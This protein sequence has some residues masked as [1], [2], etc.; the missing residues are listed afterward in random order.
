MDT[1][2]DYGSWRA[3]PWRTNSSI[4]WTLLWFCSPVAPFHK[5]LALLC[6]T[7][8]GCML[9][10]MTLSSAV[11]I[12]QEA[13]SLSACKP[14]NYRNRSPVSH[15]V[16]NYACQWFWFDSADIRAALSSR[17]PF[18]WPWVCASSDYGHCRRAVFKACDFR[19]LCFRPV[20]LKNSL[21]WFH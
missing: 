2:K 12:Q 4:N 17:A 5:L 10:L 3:L 15:Y 18:Q 16:D 8:A 19:W 11:W 20:L 13:F 9:C 21:E 7:D 14:M 1:Q 6:S